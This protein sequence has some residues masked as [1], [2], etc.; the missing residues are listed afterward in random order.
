MTRARSEILFNLLSGILSLVLPT[1][2]CCYPFEKRLIERRLMRTSSEIYTLLFR[3]II[4]LTQRIKAFD[5][6]SLSLG[7]VIR[8]LTESD[9]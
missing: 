8:V 4:C 5:G 2:M 6:G 1:Y 9:T 7:R 3:R